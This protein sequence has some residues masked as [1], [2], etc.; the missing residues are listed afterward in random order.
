[1]RKQMEQ[2]ETGAAAG[3]H[4]VKGLKK[5]EEEV[6][7]APMAGEQGEVRPIRTTTTTPAVGGKGPRGLGG[8]EST[9]MRAGAIGGGVARGEVGGLDV[10]EASGW[11]GGKRLVRSVMVS[12]AGS[13]RTG[14]DR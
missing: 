8:E 14:S 10:D 7:E 9:G 2:K 5:Q 4:P 6:K 12:G 11:T 1:M 13:D 3:K